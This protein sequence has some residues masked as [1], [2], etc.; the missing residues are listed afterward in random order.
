MAIGF[1]ARDIIEREYCIAAPG[2]DSHIEALRQV[3]ALCAN[4]DAFRGIREVTSI[5]QVLRLLKVA[6]EARSLSRSDSRPVVLM[7]YAPI[8]CGG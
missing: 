2:K 3:A 4:R 5:E 1:A 8:L 7:G 6:A